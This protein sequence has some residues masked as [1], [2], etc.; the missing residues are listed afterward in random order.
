MKKLG[1]IKHSTEP[2]DVRCKER[3]K[4]NLE[5]KFK[6]LFGTALYLF[7]T[8]NRE[9]IEK[10]PDIHKEFKSELFR[11]GNKIIQ[12]MKKEL[13]CYNITYVPFTMMLEGTENTDEG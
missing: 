7:E 1:D 6:K 4:N 5:R 13:D 11:V 8:Q 9:L 12:N 10:N 2:Y 3:L